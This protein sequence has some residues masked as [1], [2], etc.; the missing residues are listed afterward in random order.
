L[1]CRRFTSPHSYDRIAQ[2]LNEIR[3]EYNLRVEQIIKVITDNGSNFVKAFRE[4]QGDQDE[5]L[6]ENEDDETI[7]APDFITLS[8]IIGGRETENEDDTEEAIVL[9]PHERCASHTL[10]L[11]CV[12]DISDS[13]SKLMKSS[14]A[15]CYGIWNKS[16]RSTGCAEKIKDICGTYFTKPCDT[17]WNSLYDS[18][19]SLLKKKDTLNKVCSELNVPT[20]QEHELEFIQQYC[21]CVQPVADALDRLQGENHTFYGELIPTLLTVKKKLQTISAQKPKHC[22]W[23][24]KALLQGLQKRFES[25]LSLSL[26]QKDAIIAAISHLKMKLR[27]IPASKVQEMRELFIDVAVQVGKLSSP[28]NK[29]D[30][31]EPPSDNFL[32]FENAEVSARSICSDETLELTIRQE[33]VH[34]FGDN[35]TEFIML[36]KY[37]TIQQI[38]MNYNT[39]LPSS[40]PVERLFSYGSL[41]LSPKRKLLSDKNFEQLLLLKVNEY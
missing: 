21:N 39:T 12:K 32:I 22:E 5:L 14:F 8:D 41:V 27:W 10:S 3:R 29:I 23:L 6:Q 19:S 37:P 11:I 1:A 16:S 26:A 35:L 17:R 31:D 34:Y 4:Y 20:L 38:F 25:Y 18:L 33:C 7:E 15:K 40:A 24:P 13:K 28:T 36:N 2:L 9:P 30:N